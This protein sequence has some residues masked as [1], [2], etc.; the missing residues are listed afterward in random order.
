ML[1]D[2]SPVAMLT[3]GDKLPEF[4]QKELPLVN[5]DPSASWRQ[6]ATHV[7]NVEHL[8]SHNLAYVIYTSGSTGQPKGVMAEHTATV[9]RLFAQQH[10]A[11]V[12]DHD[13]CCLKTSIGFVDS[14][15]ETFAPL[16][17]G[18]TLVVI[19][20]QEVLDTHRFVEQI[21]SHNVTRLITVPSLAKV[22]LEAAE[23]GQLNS[24]RDWTLSGESVPPALPEQ[25][26]TLLPNCRVYNLY[27][28][29]EV[30]A[31]VI[32]YGIKHSQSVGSIP[33]GR[34]IS[35]T[36]VYLLDS[37]GQPVPVGAVGELYVGGA[38]VARGYLNQ[39]ELTEQRF[40]LDPFSWAQ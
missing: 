14:I 38:G 30:A 11:P 5:L 25:F 35:N 24:V 32:A 23:D 3:H 34:P 17:H 8:S 15:V 7:P 20:E 4:G 31:D 1:N 2:S 27:G 28:S 33:I 29:S 6:G 39:P 10:F 18:A 12:L 19:S 21:N 36:Y 22:L 9:N 40:I 16:V 37:Q 13:V 26:K